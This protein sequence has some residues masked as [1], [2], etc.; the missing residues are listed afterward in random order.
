MEARITAKGTKGTSLRA[1]VGNA[2]VAKSGTTTIP[3]MY[4]AG[5]VYSRAVLV[6]RAFV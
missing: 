2:A 1:L 4:S 6:H 3:V 5:W